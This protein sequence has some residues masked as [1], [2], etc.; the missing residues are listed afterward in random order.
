MG[1]TAS[2]SANQPAVQ[3]AEEMWTGLGHKLGRLA[4]GAGQGMRDAANRARNAA[5]NLERPSPGGTDAG[6]GQ[7]AERAEQMVDQWGARLGELAAAAEQQILKAAAYAR[8]D[9]ED[10]WAEAREIQRN[11]RGS[12]GSPPRGGET[13]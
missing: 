2:E 1:A 10:I 13:R 9:L 3:R 4:G 12:A 11:S 7:A 5:N 6:A 8:E